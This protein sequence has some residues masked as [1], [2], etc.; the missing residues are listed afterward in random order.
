[1]PCAGGRLP[2]GWSRVRFSEPSLLKRSLSATSDSASTRCPAMA[3]ISSPLGARRSCAEAISESACS[4]VA[5]RNLSSWRISGIVRRWVLRP[6][7]A[8]RVLS[9]IHSSL[10]LSLRRGMTRMT[11]TPRASTRIAEPRASRTSMDSTGL[12]SQGRARKA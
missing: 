11:S 1:M 7:H 5:G 3:L 12:S 2:R 4:Q 6:S 10:T 8:K 9:L